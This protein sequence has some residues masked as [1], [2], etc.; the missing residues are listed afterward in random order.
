[1]GRIVGVDLGTCRSVTATIDGPRPRV[2]QNR[3]A[4]NQTPS[5]VSLRKKKGKSSSGQAEM[6][7]GDAA[8]DNM[9]MAPKD[10][11]ISVKRLMGRAFSDPDVQKVREEYAYEVK[12][13]SDGT[14]DSVVVMVG[15]QEYSPIEISAMILT[16]LKEDAEFRLGEEVSHAVVTVPAYFSQIQ[17]DATRKAA[18]KAGLKV[19]KI[20]DEPTA[21]AIAFGLEE[22]GDDTDAK[23][24]LVFDLGGGTFDIS[25]LMWSGGTFVP[26]NKE[27][28]MWLGGDNFDQVI[29]DHVVGYIEQEFGIDPRQ[30]IRF[31]A[32]LKLKARELKERLSSSE[33]A[34]LIIPAALQDEDGDYIDLDLE[35]TRSEFER[36]AGHLVDRAAALVDKALENAALAV[37][38]VHYVVM[39][40]NS[41]CIPMV[42]RAME[43]K[44]GADKVL[45]KTH[46][47]EC[48]ALGAATVAA[49]LNGISCEAPDPEE[50]TKP[51]GRINPL[52]AVTCSKCGSP[53]EMTDE[54]RE[55]VKKQRE[56]EFGSDDI[57]PFSYGTQ[58]TG[59]QFNVFI[60]KND[61]F[62]TQDIKVL[63]FHTHSP[64]Q[65]I[66]SIPVYGGDNLVKASANEKQG[67]A[68][69]IL[70]ADIPQ[71]A[72]IRIRMWL[73][74]N[75]IFDLSAHLEN[76]TDLR[77][78]ILKGGRIQRVVEKL[79]ELLEM[80]VEAKATNPQK[81]KGIEHALEDVLNDIKGMED[82]DS[83]SDSDM[84]D[85][86]NRCQDIKNKL[87]SDAGRDDEEIRK[88]ENIVTYAQY[89]YQRYFWAIEDPN[90]S[91]MLQEAISSA[92]E[93][94]Q[95]KDM[96]KIRPCIRKL[97][98]V[99]EKLPQTISMMVWISNEIATKIRPMAPAKADDL[100]AELE[101]VAQA[102]KSKDPSGSFKLQ[103]L[104]LKVQQEIG[105]AGSLA[106][107]GN[108]ITCPSCRCQAPAGKRFCPNC[109][110]DLWVLR[111]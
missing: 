3:E 71:G 105:T 13:P 34:D 51:C 28:D 61:S 37:E 41:T 62:P 50:P 93:A 66:I 14:R 1:M 20:Q 70:P 101:Q 95:N 91:M 67:E 15:G 7:F 74:E 73:D 94:V 83:V 98:Q 77:P 27:G 19:I 6:L 42:Q 36:N 89:I 63:T 81:A 108:Q 32:N 46:P 76:G 9:V 110:N 96:A 103:Q 75:G 30:N 40:G 39:A 16:K 102:L 85:F 97:T 87:E 5:A 2:L 25:V 49:R 26:L 17:R 109:G 86:D 106:P 82:D 12:E 100:L 10:T 23:I 43:K 47:K 35:L 59:D 88:A 57:A 64:G 65:R 80:L 90:L 56:E 18:M 8:I 48:V 92:A 38:D 33:A 44:F 29:M 4:K 55:A 60:N 68:F 72:E 11:I 52:D 31:M 53:F 24:T 78:I 45:R 58:S 104:A 79:E 22:P 84:D 54:D 111:T 21:A 107:A 99:L 69:A